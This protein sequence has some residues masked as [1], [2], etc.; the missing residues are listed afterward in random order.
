MDCDFF[1]ESTTLTIKFIKKLINQ[2]NKSNTSKHN[3]VFFSLY[4]NLH[5][6][7]T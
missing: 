7:F 1:L 5:V 3:F 6:L 2:T 4:H